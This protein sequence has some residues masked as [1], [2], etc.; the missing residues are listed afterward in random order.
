MLG[1]LSFEMPTQK[2]LRKLGKKHSDWSFRFKWFSCQIY[3]ILQ[4]VVAKRHLSTL[5]IDIL[6]IVSTSV[7]FQANFTVSLRFFHQSVTT[8]RLPNFRFE[9]RG[10]MKDMLNIFCIDLIQE[11]QSSC[12]LYQQQRKFLGKVRNWTLLPSERLKLIWSICC[13]PGEIDVDW[14][15]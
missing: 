9:P 3:K 1:I 7:S 5:L 14:A 8:R 11:A 12:D 4:L 13:F 10:T 15:P 2:V 6:S